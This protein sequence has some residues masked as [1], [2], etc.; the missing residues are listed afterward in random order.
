MNDGATRHPEAE[1]MSAFVE[2]K[3]AP[4]EVARIAEHLRGCGDCRTVVGET[5]RFER[6][7]TAEAAPSEGRTS[8][9]RSWWLAAA[10]A[11]GGAIA[12]TVPLLQRTPALSPI[13]ILIEAAP[14]EH[15]TV[16]GRLSGFPWAPPKVGQR[17]APVADPADLKLA[18]AAGTVLEQT[19]RKEDAESLHAKGLAHLLIGETAQGIAALERAA[20][21]SNDAR[22]W[23]DLA[24]ARHALVI[25]DERTAQLPEALAAADR[26]IRIDANLPEAHFNRA[27]ILEQ[28]GV[29]G[30]ARKEWERYLALDSGSAWSAEAREK[31]RALEKDSVQF[32][33]DK[34]LERARVALSRGDRTGIEALVRERPQ[35]SRRRGESVLLNDWA[36]AEATGDVALAAERLEVVRVIGD[37]LLALNGETLLMDAVDV[38]DRADR[39]TRVALVD[40]QR[41]YNLAGSAYRDRQLGVAKP[42][43]LRAQSL[44]RSAKSPL[45]EMATY[46]SA[47]VALDEGQSARAAEI[48][49]ALRSRI[50]RTRY[51]ALSAQIASDMSRY[52]TMAGDWGTAARESEASASQFREIGERGH[53]SVAESIGAHAMERIGA[54][55]LAWKRRTSALTELGEPDRRRVL[56]SAALALAAGDHL[57]AAESV[58]DV[59]IEDGRKGNPVLL[60]NALI[61]RAGYAERTGDFSGSRRWL[62]EAREASSRISDPALRERADAQIALRDAGL[63]IPRDA[64]AAIESINRVIAFFLER[65]P[66]MRLP[67]AY[68]Q[69]ARAYR[70]LGRSTEALHDYRAAANEIEKQRRTITDLELPLAFLD[71]AAPIIEET[72]EL[73]L[74]EGA[75]AEALRALDRAHSTFRRR[76]KPIVMPPGTALLEY[77]VLP[78]EVAIFCVTGEQVSVQRV[79]IERQLLDQRIQSLTGKIRAASSI[80]EIRTEA[81]SLYDLLIR[82]ILAVL[83]GAEE[84]VIVPDRQLHAL[85]FAVLYNDQTQLYL[86]EDYTLRFSPSAPRGRLEP[87]MSLAPA[88]VIADPRTRWPGL[89]FSRSEAQRVAAIHSATVLTGASAT[90]PAVLELMTRSSL[91]HYAGHA[92]SDAAESYGA[93]LLTPADG[94]DGILGTSEIARLPLE[95]HRP[96]V[97]L[98]A[99]GTFRGNV[100]HV[101]GMPSLA[102]AFLSA[103]ARAV[104]GTLWEMEDDLAPYLFSSFHEHLRTGMAP[105]RALRSAQIEMLRSSDPRL[106]HP[107]TWSPVEVLSNY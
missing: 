76:E 95:K 52:A 105:A 63:K 23:N 29:R 46:Y 33:F 97:V 30:E 69:R 71:G 84:V 13:Q 96:L 37:S 25:R 20:Q 7:R 79:L 47:S 83:G 48:L 90:R 68:L 92:D 6:E 17:G 19:A 27:L 55:D 8:R 54:S 98:S 85:S 87:A 12:L 65:G 51:R 64:F 41:T 24:A 74:S 59:M 66:A 102:R 57:P 5:A 93:L 104:V 107:S 103:G 28:M 38:I 31:L 100:T 72:I 91:I 86:F 80:D 50:D 18:G 94:D 3:L 4:G 77:V 49:T 58:V 1:V 36:E 26:A 34:A 101:A 32:D 88:V 16:D 2:G 45:A 75:N 39:T 42:G 62:A 21:A 56:H 78:H 106:S 43:F 89:P 70:A 73:L 14:S 35:D 99:C 11:I 10:A 81:T 67:D 9:V 40:A 60:T 22:M 15:R 82:P 44:F 53:A 61:D